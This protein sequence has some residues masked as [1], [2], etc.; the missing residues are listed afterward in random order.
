MTAA[1]EEEGVI[2]KGNDGGTIQLS[3]YKP[4]RMGRMEDTNLM[5]PLGKT[6]DSSLVRRILLTT[7][8]GHASK[9]IQMRG[10]RKQSAVCTSQNGN[11]DV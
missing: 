5:S 11:R 8:Q 3:A 10:G 7:N 6:I 1:T 2:V 9:N 4:P